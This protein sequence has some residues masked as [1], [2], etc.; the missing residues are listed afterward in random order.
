ML[1]S[2]TDK[3]TNDKLLTRIGEKYYES[4]M[5]ASRYVY[6]GPLPS[7]YLTAAYV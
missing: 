2:K 4:S 1:P 5:G 7:P 3:T 6:V